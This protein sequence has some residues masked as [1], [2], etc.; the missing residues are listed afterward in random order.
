M[1][2]ATARPRRG[3]ARWVIRVGHERVVD[4]MVCSR[5][6]PPQLSLER[7]MVD[8][9]LRGVPF[10]GCGTAGGG[11]VVHYRK[12][13]WVCSFAGRGILGR[14]GGVGYGLDFGVGRGCDG[15]RVVLADCAGGVEGCGQS[16]AVEEGAGAYSADA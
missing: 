3:L 8:V 11:C 10:V 9:W 4:S 2:R 13:W 1:S 6:N 16:G 15:D 12:R 7:D 5:R 14:S